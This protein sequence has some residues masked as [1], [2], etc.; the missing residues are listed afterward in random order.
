MNLIVAAPWWL[1]ALLMLALG[2]AAVEDA[3]RYRISNL[4]CAAVLIAALVAVAVQ[5]FSSGLWQNFALFAAFLA[6]GTLAFAAGWLGGGDVKLLA[7]IGLWLDLR[8]AV[9]LIAAVFIAGGLVALVYIVARRMVH[10]AGP[11]IG[12]HAQIPYGLAV[13]AGALFMFGTQ[14][15]HPHP[16]K[17]VD[18]I[19]AMEAAAA[20][21]GR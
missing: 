15:S 7:S 4:T 9:G 10:A 2:A 16:T 1:I 14:L 13:V 19:R 21:N 11:S 3:V 8:A 17:Y 6:V 5:G 12:R 20:A 18:R